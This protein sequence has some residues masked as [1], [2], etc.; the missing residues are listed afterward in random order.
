MITFAVRL[1]VRVPCAVS[2]S[3]R[4]SFDEDPL[5]AIYKRPFI[6]S[7][8]LVDQNC[9]NKRVFFKDDHLPVDF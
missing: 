9:A 1:S 3:L 8:N 4:E 5:T 2:Y 7:S 6:E